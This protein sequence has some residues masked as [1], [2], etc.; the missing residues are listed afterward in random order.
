MTRAR[1][2]DRRYIEHGADVEIELP[3]GDVTE[4]VVRVGDTVR[5]PHQPQSFA[6]GAYLDHLEAV[7]FDASPRFL[8][9]DDRGRDV[10]TFIDGRVAGAELEPWVLS[11]ELLASVAV[12]VRRLHE[13]SACYD[14]AGE[15]FPPKFTPVANPELISHLDVTPQNVV[16]RGERAIGLVDFDLAGRTTR[17]LDSYNTAM[18]WAPLR[19][20][21]DIGADWSG[22]DPLHRVRVFADA[23]GWTRDERM[24]LPRFAAERAERSWAAMKHHA[25]QYGGGWARM[26]EEGVGDVI[27]RRREWLLSNETRIQGALAG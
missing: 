11:E 7:G 17:L 25:E 22:T 16:T 18:H 24:R 4:G 19:Y 12:L 21:V 27:L 1:V 8:G 15:P 26:W 6:V 13:A 23:Y 10:L 14:D 20:P 5:R 2:R 3:S 9:R